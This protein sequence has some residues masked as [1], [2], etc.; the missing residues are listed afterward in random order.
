MCFDARPACGQRTATSTP[1]PTLTATPTSVRN[2]DLGIT[3]TASPNP[4]NPGALLTYEIQVHNYGDGSTLESFVFDA[5]PSEVGFVSCTLHV[6]PN[7]YPPPYC[8]FGNGGIA[9]NLGLVSRT[10]TVSM[11]VVV[12]VLAAS[13]TITNSASV[14]HRGP[15]PNPSNNTSTVVTIIGPGPP[16]TPTPTATATATATAAP[17]ATVTAIPPPTWTPDLHYTAMATATAAPTAT[18]IATAPPTWTPDLHRTATPTTTPTP[19]GGGSA[20]PAIPTLSPIARAAF[21]LALLAVGWFLSS[22]RSSS[23]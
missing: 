15:D 2:D 8:R 20:D 13:G 22:S 1:T 6:S 17:T 14:S 4:V 5:L 3:K 23:S 7:Q 11:T 21:L 12:Q 18:V 9:A 10:Q 16:F 19:I